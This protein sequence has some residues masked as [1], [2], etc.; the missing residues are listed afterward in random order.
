M[1]V[2]YFEWVL[3]ILEAGG[4]QHEAAARDHAGVLQMLHTSVSKR[5]DMRAAAYTL[6]IQ[7][8]ADASSVRGIYP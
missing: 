5:L 2:S 4:G 6:G 3:D 1:I 8:V 7:R